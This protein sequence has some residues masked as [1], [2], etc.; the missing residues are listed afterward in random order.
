MATAS[1]PHWG[2]GLPGRGRRG[3]GGG[4]GGSG[5]RPGRPKLLT[6]W[7]LLPPAARPGPSQWAS[8][9]ASTLGETEA[10]A[11]TQHSEKLLKIAPDPCQGKKDPGVSGTKGRA[12]LATSPKL[13]ACV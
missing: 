13:A 9:A 2:G 8:M 10:G 3:E 11:G 7:L 6:R 5:R 12:A 4:G 1:R